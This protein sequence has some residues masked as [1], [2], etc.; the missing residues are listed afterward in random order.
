MGKIIKFADGGSLSRRRTSYIK[1]PKFQPITPDIPDIEGLEKLAT[2]FKMPAGTKRTRTAVDT[3]LVDIDGH[4]AEV[5]RI[6]DAFMGELDQINYSISS[7]MLDRDSWEVEVM[8]KRAV[9]NM[10][11]SKRSAEVQWTLAKENWSKVKNRNAPWQ[12]PKGQYLLARKIVKKNEDGTVVLNPQ[13]EKVLLR[14]WTKKHSEYGPIISYGDEF[15]L[16]SF[17]NTYSPVGERAPYTGVYQLSVEESMDYFK[18]ILGQAGSVGT[19]KFGLLSEADVSKMA[20]ASTPEQLFEIIKQKTKNN[21]SNLQWAKGILQAAPDNIRNPLMADWAQKVQ[22]GRYDAE[23]EDFYNSLI[24]A[25]VGVHTE[26]DQS[27]TGGTDG[28]GSDDG[29]DAADMWSL[30]ANGTLL[31]AGRHRS[32]PETFWT[33]DADNEWRGIDLDVVMWDAPAKFMTKQNTILK[34]EIF[35]SA[36]QMTETGYLDG[37][38]VDFSTDV[39]GRVMDPD[40]I[41]DIKFISGHPSGFS[42]FKRKMVFVNDK[43]GKE[44]LSILRPDLEDP[45]NSNANPADAYGEES[46]QKP[47]VRGKMTNVFLNASVDD[48]APEF[49]QNSSIHRII[50]PS[51]EKYTAAMGFG[52]SDEI[53]AMYVDVP[54]DISDVLALELPA[55]TT[56]RII[57]N[58]LNK[59]ALKSNSYAD[60]IR[61][62]FKTGLPPVEEPKEK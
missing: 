10:L 20:A 44:A 24:D 22:Q 15:D 12:D 35:T 59:E 53:Y 23:S 48:R 6:H 60:W 3:K 17:S 30:A 34:G 52:E 2:P 32:K 51:A 13:P 18:K 41:T 31:T 54:M 7:G 49:R 43:F 1:A 14:D 55:A 46:T 4:P 29:L 56:R 62:A 28:D 45:R 5:K 50:G 27:I 21:A 36:N 47:G 26:F 38:E 61:H 25:M 58:Y 9:N 39:K 11:S 40:I 8:Q 57:E 42:L 37:T 19:T 33:R 16:Q